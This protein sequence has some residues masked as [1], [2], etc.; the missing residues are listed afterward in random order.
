MTRFAILALVALCTLGTSARAS[1]IVTILQEGNNVVA[2]G[3]GTI[4]TA[5]LTFQNPSNSEAL[6]NASVGV[7]VLGP[8][9]GMSNG[10]LVTYP[11]EIYYGA[12]GP[13][14]F[15]SG[16]FFEGT[17]GGGNIVAI[18]A[19]EPSIQ[20]PGSVFVPPGYVSGASLSDSAAWDNATFSSLGLTPG[21]YTWTWGSGATADFFEV[22]IGPPS[23]PSAVPEPSGTALLFMALGTIGPY[24]WMR[25]RRA[26][27]AA[28]AV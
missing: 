4:D 15:G 28:M 14:S 24:A 3:S 8:P 20:L 10:F 6:I 25:R 11:G 5:A 9:L 7:V 16:G 22:Q 18:S 19:A 1:F 27:A 12:I 2:T 17:T 26:G 13:L 23:A 21:T